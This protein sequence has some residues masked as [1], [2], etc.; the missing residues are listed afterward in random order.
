MRRFKRPVLNPAQHSLSNA[1]CVNGEQSMGGIGI[2]E[3]AV[4]LVVGLGWLIGAGVLY[5]V[6]RAAI[7]HGNRDR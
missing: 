4:L 2:T 5:A 7:R 1:T 6:I 3:I